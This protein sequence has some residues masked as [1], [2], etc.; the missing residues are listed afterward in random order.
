MPVARA[1]P[2]DYDGRGSGPRAEGALTASAANLV[3]RVNGLTDHAEHEVLPE[4]ILRATGERGSAKLPCRHGCRRGTW[5]PQHGVQGAL[6]SWGIG[7]VLRQNHSAPVRFAASSHSGLTPFLKSE[8]DSTV[9][10]LNFF[11]VRPS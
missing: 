10:S 2:V 9:R 8:K 3:R 4:R 6:T 1:G 7:K 11:L 5:V